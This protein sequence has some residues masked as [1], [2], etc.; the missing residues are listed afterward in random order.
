MKR[1]LWYSLVL[2]L[3]NSAGCSEP[4]SKSV[5][6]VVKTKTYHTAGCPRVNMAN[7]GVMTVEDARQIECAPCP[8]CHPDQPQ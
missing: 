8:G 6:V 3:L 1:F 2:L 7:A 4:P 5:Y